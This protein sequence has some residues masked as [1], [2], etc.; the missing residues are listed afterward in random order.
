[1]ISAT[2]RGKSDIVHV[3]R[4]KSFHEP[5][6]EWQSPQTSISDNTEPTAEKQ[7]ENKSEQQEE[8]RDL[9]A[10]IDPQPQTEEEVTVPK[11]INVLPDT[12]GKE[13]ITSPPDQIS[14]NASRRPMRNRRPPARCTAHSEEW[15]FP[16]SMEGNKMVRKL[17]AV[18][19]PSVKIFSQDFN[20]TVSKKHTFMEL[21]RENTCSADIISQLLHQN[22]QASLSTEMTEE[23]IYNLIIETKKQKEAS[24]IGYPYELVTAILLLAIGII[25]L[26]YKSYAL[27]VRLATHELYDTPPP[28]RG[29]S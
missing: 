28:V 1:M 3:A 23:E 4:M 24:S 22:A 26:A 16:S 20:T 7:Q 19:P 9:P 14:S 5:T 21:P 25:S 18:V 10:S 12:S 2:G 29:K 6:F 17:Q 15:V 8:A 13:V 11:E 27:S